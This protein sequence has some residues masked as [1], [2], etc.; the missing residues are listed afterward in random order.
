VSQWSA[1][2]TSPLQFALKRTV[3]TLN[4]SK[5]KD[6]PI[7][8]KK[9]PALLAGGILWR[10][11]RR[12][13]GLISTNGDLTRLDCF[14]F[15]Q[16]DSQQTLFNASADF[17]R[18]DAGIEIENAAEFASLSF[19]MHRSPEFT[20]QRSVAAEDQFAVLDGDF[21]ALLVHAGHF[22]FESVTVSI[23]VKVNT[24][25]EILHAL[26]RFNRGFRCR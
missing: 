19:T 1:M 7:I 3:L 4:P 5:R 10:V 8:D 25:R 22:H 6:R 15:G 21:H 11:A 12:Q 16:M 18:I 13:P 26:S 14:G 9:N 23:L 24:R 20:R 2:R 17:R